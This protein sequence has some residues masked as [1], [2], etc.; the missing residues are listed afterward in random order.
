MGTRTIGERAR[1]DTIKSKKF[2]D[3]TGQTNP[4]GVKFLEFRGFAANGRNEGTSF[5]AWL[6]ECPHCL[7]QFEAWS[8]SFVRIKHCGCHFGKYHGPLRPLR[9]FW[10]AMIASNSCSQ[11]F[12]SWETFISHVPEIPKGMQ[13]FRPDDT[14]P[15]GPD[16]FILG[17][18]KP[19]CRWIT[20]I[21][22]SHG[23]ILVISEVC[24]LLKCSRQNVWAMNQENLQARLDAAVLASR[25]KLGSGDQDAAVQGVDV[26]V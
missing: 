18:K 8:T 23:E 9:H 22:Q 1:R 17:K 4:H 13:L 2:I 26:A 25:S 24:A 16:N 14:R 21:W 7:K 15:L 3:R 5:G 11:E 6:V 20:R 12:R 10:A 19:N